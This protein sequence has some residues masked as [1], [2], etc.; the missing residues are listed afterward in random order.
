MSILDFY[1]RCVERADSAIRLT[2]TADHLALLR[3]TYVSWNDAEFGAPTLDPKRP[4]GNSDVL[5][6]LR[7]IG[8]SWGLDMSTE[9]NQ[10]R[11]VQLHADLLPVMRIA[12]S[13]FEFSTG[14]YTRLPYGRTWKKVQEA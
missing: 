8:E 10:R 7:E 5:D 11:M 14:T 4:Y 1:E 9:D 6:D 3:R 13:T 12:M 2:V